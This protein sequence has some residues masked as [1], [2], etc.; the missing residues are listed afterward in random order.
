MIVTSV[1][2]AMLMI[3]W[4][5][6][7]NGSPITNRSTALSSAAIARTLRATEAPPSRGS[8]QDTS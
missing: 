7:E 8:Y 2:W 5:T 3:T 6:P 1:G 4:M